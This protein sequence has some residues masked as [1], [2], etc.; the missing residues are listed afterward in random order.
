MSVQRRD[1]H[2]AQCRDRLTSATRRLDDLRNT[3][4]RLRRDDRGEFERA[5]DGLR[6][7]HNRAL[8]RLEAARLAQP[9]SWPLARAQADQALDDLTRRLDE[10]ESHI[11][12]RQAA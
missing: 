4:E 9:E 6:G 10:V 12:Q 7:L 2:E 11:Q 8:A 3:V 1:T 5:L